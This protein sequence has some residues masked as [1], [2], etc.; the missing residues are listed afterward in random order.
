MTVISGQT[1]KIRFGVADASNWTHDETG[2]RQLGDRIG[3]EDGGV[4]IQA[5]IGDVFIIPA[6]VSH[7]TFAPRP[8]TRGL[9]FL[10][11]E[12]IERGEAAKRLDKGSEERHRQFFADVRV[13]G[14]FMMMGAYPVGGTWDFKIG[15]EHE[16]REKVVW[17]VP[18]PGRDPVLG[19]SEEGMVGLWK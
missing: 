16:G 17:S 8:E 2:T 12:D 9:A 6:G 10:Q 3:G 13:E 11:P 1:A 5:S 19:K 14:D 4:E 18:V 7:K 15:G